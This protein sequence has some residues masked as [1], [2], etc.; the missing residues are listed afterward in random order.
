[1]TDQGNPE[2][3]KAIPVRH[4]GRWIATFVIFV[5]VAMFI[6]MALTNPNFEW[7]VIGEYLFNNKILEGV[8]ATVWITIDARRNFAGRSAVGDAPIT[9][10]TAF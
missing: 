9:K 5:L 8:W 3:I 6:N 2:S 7:G 4:P 10:P 1:M